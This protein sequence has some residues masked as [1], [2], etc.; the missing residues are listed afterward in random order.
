VKAHSPFFARIQMQV[1]AIVKSIPRGR[2]VTF[3][4]IG[5]HLD[6]VPRHVAYILAKLTPAER[7]E[8]PWHRAVPAKGPPKAGADLLLQE[9]VL[10]TALGIDPSAIIDVA[11]LKHGVSKQSRPIEA[12]AARPKR[13]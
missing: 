10:A 9:G 11:D 4:N 2:V 8:L 13:R 3:A 1:F 6:V 5:A 7:V 12:P